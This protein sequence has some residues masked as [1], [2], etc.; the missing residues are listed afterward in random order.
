MNTDRL[1]T[2]CN[3]I[4]NIPK[5]LWDFDDFVTKITET[6]QVCGCALGHCPE[7]WPNEFTIIDSD[8]YEPG[9]CPKNLS[10]PKGFFYRNIMD[11]AEEFFDISYCVAESI[12]FCDYFG[13]RYNVTQQMFIEKVM[14]LIN[15]HK[16]KELINV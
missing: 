9:E 10:T 13:R 8:N 4:A 11:H 14:T 15:K 12:F 3:H 2:L 5:E 16:E 6:G 1:L 7:I